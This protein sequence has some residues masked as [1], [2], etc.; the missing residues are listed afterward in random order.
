VPWSLAPGGPR[1]VRSGYRLRF[2]TG[3]SSSGASSSAKASTPVRRRSP[4][5]WAAR[6]WVRHRPRPSGGYSTPQDSLH[7]SRI[8]VRAAPGSASSVLAIV[9]ETDVTLVAFDTGE[10]LSSHLIEPDKGYWRNQRR[11]PGRWPG[12]QVSS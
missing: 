8:S 2:V 1:R 12:S 9:D 3:S 6:A 5:T 10:V 11:N 7:P 4:G